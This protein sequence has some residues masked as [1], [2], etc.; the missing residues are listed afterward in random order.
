MSNHDAQLIVIS[1][2]GLKI[3]NGKPKTIRKIDKYSM[4]DFQI[5][6]SFETWDSIFGNNDVNTMFSSF[7]SP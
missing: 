6:L 1:D 4:S 5:E 2:I 7:L 3:Q